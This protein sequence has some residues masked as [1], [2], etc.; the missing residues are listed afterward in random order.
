MDALAGDPE[1]KW[2]L[3]VVLATL[4]GEMLVDEA[5]DELDVGPTQ[6]ANLRK[7]A[8]QAALDGLRP[9]PVGRPRQTSTRSEAEV[10]A[11]QQRIDELEHEAQLLRSRLELAILPLLKEGRR[12]KSRRPPAAGAGPG[13]AA[14]S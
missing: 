6:F 14:P 13:T 12:S 11:M 4:T 1:D 9:K 2:R 10:E 8:L 3:K 5:L 7:Q